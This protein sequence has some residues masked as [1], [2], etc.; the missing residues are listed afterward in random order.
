MDK[1]L[2][3]VANQE[4]NLGDTQASADHFE[5]DEDVDSKGCW[6]SFRFF[7][8][9]SFRDISRRKCH[10]CLALCSVLIVV[11]STLVVNTVTSKGPI[12]FMKLGEKN[13]G[14]IDATIDLNSARSR[15]DSNHDSGD[16][17][18]LNF[19]RAE[20]VLTEQNIDYH[21]SPRYQIC[22]AADRGIY[23]YNKDGTELG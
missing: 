16:G 21:I 11:L 14:E 13:Y 6:Q 7:L 23:I 22:D 3:H 9:H 8:R 12:I 4:S 2:T 10:F 15:Q 19:T 20:Q 18:S 5:N 17:A 1:K